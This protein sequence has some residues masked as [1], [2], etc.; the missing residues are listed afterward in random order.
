MLKKFVLGSMVVVAALLGNACG[1]DG[2]NDSPAGPA[3]GEATLAYA[4]EHGL[5]FANLMKTIWL[6]LRGNCKE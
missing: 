1:D 3:D 5:S 6:Y 2:S 4:R